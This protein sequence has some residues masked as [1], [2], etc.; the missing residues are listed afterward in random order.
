MERSG[1]KNVSRTALNFI[2]YEF[3]K[4]IGLAKSFEFKSLKA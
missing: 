3:K 2:V 1:Y 4:F